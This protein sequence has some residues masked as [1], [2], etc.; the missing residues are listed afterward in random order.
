M[1]THVQ[2]E[3]AFLTSTCQ[4]FGRH[5]NTHK[6][7]TA[8][9]KPRQVP[10]CGLKCNNMFACNL[11]TLCWNSWLGHL[12]WSDII[13][14]IMMSFY[15]HFAHMPNVYWKNTYCVN[16]NYG[17]LFILTIYLILI[18][19]WSFIEY[20]SKFGKIW[21]CQL[22]PNIKLWGSLLKLTSFK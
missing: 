17:N 16:M 8:D 5:A 10:Q 20:Y 15:S 7:R 1:H 12:I 13:G 22:F 3:L 14:A 11:P 9:A 21:N 2:V 6:Q 19:N 18:F 4:H